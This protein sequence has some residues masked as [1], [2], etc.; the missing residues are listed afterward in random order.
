MT[1]R[2]TLREEKEVVELELEKSTQRL[3][4]E[5]AKTEEL[6]HTLNKVYG[7]CGKKM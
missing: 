5:Q 3:L 2:K 6:Q 7:Y 4:Q 1:I